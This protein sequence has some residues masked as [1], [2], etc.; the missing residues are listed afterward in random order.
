RSETSS[1]FQPEINFLKQ[2]RFTRRALLYAFAALLFVFAPAAEGALAPSLFWPLYG[3][4]AAVVI[5]AFASD[6]ARAKR[7]ALTFASVALTITVADLALRLTPIVPNELAERWPPM[8]L[9]NRY[10]PGLNYEGRR[11]ND[12]SR[13]AGVKEWRE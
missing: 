12:L 13:M 3:S 8:P 10:R 7:A 1:V 5:Y 2:M 11:F 9:V 4:G 6:S